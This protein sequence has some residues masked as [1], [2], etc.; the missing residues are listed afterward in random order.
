MSWKLRSC[1]AKAGAA[2][3]GADARDQLGGRERLLDEVVG[4]GVQLA[5]FGLS[6]RA[7]SMMIGQVMLG[8]RRRRR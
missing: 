2:Q 5:L 4:T 8:R 7:A 1:S 3:D 6:P